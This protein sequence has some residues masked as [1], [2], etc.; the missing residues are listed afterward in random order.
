MSK[1][2]QAAGEMSVIGRLRVHGA[3][4][5]RRVDRKAL[6]VIAAI[7]G[8]LFL[9]ATT[10]RAIRPPQIRKPAVAAVIIW[11]GHSI[12]HVQRDE[13]CKTLVWMSPAPSDD[14]GAKRVKAENN[15][16]ML[17]LDCARVP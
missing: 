2:D 8:L 11:Q 10:F 9:A 14:D 3:R 4:I 16:D 5:L 6:F 7:I 15:S 1:E 17:Q 12:T 13:I